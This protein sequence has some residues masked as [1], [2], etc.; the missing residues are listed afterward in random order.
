MIFIRSVYP[1]IPSL[2]L[3]IVLTFQVKAQAPFIQNYPP[4]AYRGASQNWDVMQDAAGIIYVANNDGILQYDGLH[5]RLIPLPNKVFAYSLALAPDGKIYVGATNELGYLSRNSSGQIN[6]TS[7]NPLLTKKTSQI[8][9]VSN[10]RLVGKK[11]VFQTREKV[12]VYQNG[13]FQVF[14][15]RA[16]DVFIVQ[17]RLYFRKQKQLLE[18]TQGTLKPTNALKGFDLSQ[19]K[20]IIPL[21]RERWLLVD[22]NNQFWLRQQQQIKQVYKPFNKALKQRNIIDVHPLSSDRLAIALYR[23]LFI[24][25]KSG[26]IIYQLNQQ[27]GLVNS[28]INGLWEDH[29]HN[30]WLATNYGVAQLMINS[31]ITQY[32]KRNG[33]KGTIYSLGQHHQYTYVGTNWGV[34]FKTPNQRL[35]KQVRGVIGDNWNFYRFNNDLYLANGSGVYQIK[36]STA[37]RLASFTYVHSLHQLRNFKNRFIVGTYSSGIWLLHKKGTQWVK[38]KIKGFEQ[39]TRFIQEDM[40]GDIWIAHYNKGVYRLKLNSQ[41][42]SVIQKD[43]YDQSKGLPSNKNNRIYRRKNGQI[44]AATTKGFYNYNAIQDRFLPVHALNVALKGQ[45]C[46]YTF[47]EDAKGNVYCWLGQSSPHNK[48]T[49]GLLKKQTD[50]S[51]QLVTNVFNNIAVPTNNVRVDIDAPILM[52]PNGKVWIGNLK[53]LLVYDPEQASSIDQ[54]YQVLIKQVQANDSIIFRYGSQSKTFELPYTNNN[55][56]VFFSAITYENIE[57]TRYSFQLNTFQQKWSDWSSDP[58]VSFTNLPEGKYTLKVKAKNI[59]D[60]ESL[61]S[62]FSFVILPPWYRTWWAYTLYV[63]GSIALIFLIV[64][65]NSI[66][67]IKQKITLERIVQTRTEEIRAQNEE[68]QQNQDEILAQRNYIE[69]Q[70]KHLTHQNNLIQQSIKSALTIQ[71][72]LLPFDSRIGK[73]LSDYFVVYLPKDIVSGDFYWIEKIDHQIFIIAADCTGHGV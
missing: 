27:S 68:L 19:L 66:R 12:F 33:L 23:E 31:P 49:A 62:S 2:I 20:K 69:G 40:L 3:C 38:K 35:F 63:I 44:I 60:K 64:R 72:A 1:T 13:D 58:K 21:T 28:R 16:N 47:Q 6:Y 32:T 55:I 5:W 36:D 54:T 52:L 45:Y 67:L 34:F 59:Y 57:Q 43:F 18:Y 56:K 8:K 25:N 42:D 48:E 11:V 24:L 53:R 37:T 50:G 39:E 29:Q 9:T 73:F 26:E 61:V 4:E 46:V 71:E 17:E 65:L 7:L 51:Y 22:Y 10:V 15:Y 70:N 14:N 30:L 41:L